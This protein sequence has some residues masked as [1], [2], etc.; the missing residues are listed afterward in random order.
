MTQPLCA[1]FVYGT[2]KRGHANH[3]L[4]ASSIRAIE[5]GSITGVLYDLGDFPALGE[6]NGTVRG[7]LIWIDPEQMA[8][9]LEVVDRL[10]AY[11]PDDE[12]GSMYRRRTVRARTERGEPVSAYTYF[13]NADHPLLPPP[14]MLPRLPDGEW[15]GT[16]PLPLTESVI[17][18][19]FRQSVRTF[20]H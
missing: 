6:G 14:E 1:F 10:E 5:P 16:R 2:L 4:L 3:G 8:Q 12:P 19:E 13:Y 7:E 11:R 18:E 9:V 20:R 15:R 17:L